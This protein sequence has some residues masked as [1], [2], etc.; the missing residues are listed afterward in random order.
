[1]IKI[2]IKLKSL[3]TFTDIGPKYRYNLRHN[4]NFDN[5]LMFYQMFVSSQV[6]RIVIISNTV[7]NMVYASCL[8]I[9]QTTDRLIEWLTEW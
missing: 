1:M 2:Q 8:T 4:I 5:N 6:K 9:C 3:T 7:I